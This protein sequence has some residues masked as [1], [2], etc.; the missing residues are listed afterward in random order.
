MFLTCIIVLISFFSKA[1][2]SWCAE[3]FTWT[4]QTV[5]A[6]ADCDILKPKMRVEYELLTNKPRC[7]EQVRVTTYDEEQDK[8]GEFWFHLGTPGSKN[9][10]EFTNPL[11]KAE[12]CK[13][14]PV[15]ISAVI[16]QNGKRKTLLTTFSLNPHNCITAGDVSFASVLRTQ[17]Q[18][19]Q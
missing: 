1:E 17:L 5:Q 16:H 3:Y 4:W 6:I 18:L 19:Q 10:A 15:S 11:S 13:A 9:F 8:E 7:L 2:S 12:I 14:T